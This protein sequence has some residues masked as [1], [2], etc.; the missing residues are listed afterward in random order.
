MEFKE[1]RKW[2]KSLP[3]SMRW[4]VWLVFLRPLIDNFYYL[5]EV[6]PVLSPLNVVGVLTPV[7]IYFSIRKVKKPSSSV[8][9]SNFRI[10]GNML[11]AGVIVMGFSGLFLM[12]YWVVAFKLLLPVY[13]FIFLRYFVR[14]RK[15]V[16]GILQTFLYSAMFIILMFGYEIFFHP[17]MIGFTRKMERFQGGYADVFNYATYVS[18]STLINYYFLLKSDSTLSKKARLRN[19][20]INLVIGPTM[21]I[22]MSHVASYAVFLALNILYFLIAFRK[23]TISLLLCLTIILPIVYIYGKETINDKFMP[24]IQTDIEAYSGERDEV[25]LL[26]G[27]VGRWESQTNFFNESSLFVQLFGFPLSCELVF[28]LFT[29]GTHND[30]LRILFTTGYVGL[31]TYILLLY[32]LFKR[33]MKH[34]WSLLYLGLGA[35]ACLMLYSLSVTP[36]VYASYMYIVMSIFALFSIPFQN[37]RIKENVAS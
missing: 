31:L 37:F 22:K 30:Y 36:T 8:I 20:V 33:I 3:K 27:R 12:S 18:L 13:L 2:Y 4:F 17:I 19:V 1:W 28:P 21:L 24:L 32:N 9:D 7:L 6:S 16:D 35:L 26:H 11:L 25:Q 5:K 29:G 34:Y 14:N 15:D 23:N 10:W